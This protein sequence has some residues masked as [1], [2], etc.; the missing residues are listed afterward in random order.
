MHSIC[1]VYQ[2]TYV[3]VI[4]YTTC[5]SHVHITPCNVLVYT[6]CIDMYI[7]S[8]RYLCRLGNK[9]LWEN[10]SDEESD[11]NDDVLEN[12]EDKEEGSVD[13]NED[14]NEDEQDTED[15]KE[16]IDE[17]AAIMSALGLPTSFGSK[18]ATC[19]LEVP[20]FD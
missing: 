15:N 10:A 14:D 8:D 6:T 4:V 5:I 11:G 9:D 12:D 3:H 16:C 7:F 17:E 13:D 1:I 19:T 2:C 20:S 18:T